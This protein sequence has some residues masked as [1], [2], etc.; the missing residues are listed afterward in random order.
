MQPIPTGGIVFWPFDPSA[1]PR[2]WQNR[3]DL[4]GRF[5]KGATANDTVGQLESS[6]FAGHSHGYAM[7]P[8][9][10]DSDMVSKVAALGLFD[11]NANGATTDTRSLV[12]PATFDP[13]LSNHETRAANIYL[14]FAAYGGGGTPDPAAASLP[15]GTILPWSQPAGAPVP[16]GWLLCNGDPCDPAK[17]P[18][19]HGLLTEASSPFGESGGNPKLPSLGGKFV[20]GVQD[21]KTSGFDPEYDK[22]HAPGDPHTKADGIGSEQDSCIHRHQHGYPKFPDHWSYFGGANHVLFT[23]DDHTAGDATTGPSSNGSATYPAHVALPHLIKATSDED[24]NPP[25]MGAIIIYAGGANAVLHLAGQG[26]SRCDGGTVDGP[27]SGKFDRGVYP[28]MEGLFIRCVDPGTPPVTDLDRDS[29]RFRYKA[30]GTTPEAHSDV[31]S[32]QLSALQTHSHQVSIAVDAPMSPGYGGDPPQPEGQYGPNGFSGWDEPS[33]EVSTA[34]PAD[35]NAGVETRPDNVA[36]YF[37]ISS[38]LSKA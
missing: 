37:L 27:L 33:T 17:F 34:F 29:T 12:A 21:S 9:A 10:T 16:H 22:R 28:N 26:W 24:S 8:S 7:F 25:P 31:L 4:A 38:G 19:L 1:L 20:R 13:K 15:I 11:V 3:T 36:L 5:I 32:L 18:A 30:D 2:G 14:H 6:A 23:S 35:S